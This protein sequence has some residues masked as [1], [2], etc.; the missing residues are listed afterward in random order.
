[1]MSATANFGDGH[2]NPMAELGPHTELVM[3][4]EGL[5][6]SDDTLHKLES[7]RDHIQETIGFTFSARIK[8]EMSQTLAQVE[9]DI[10]RLQ[11]GNC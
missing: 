4:Q 8:A 7:L 10:R 3:K 9:A 6:G 11:A 5:A 2:F 1:M